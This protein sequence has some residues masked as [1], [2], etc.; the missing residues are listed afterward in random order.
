MAERLALRGIVER[1]VADLAQHAEAAA[2]FRL[3]FANLDKKELQR[4]VELLVKAKK[5]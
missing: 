1:A 3:G 2:H 4:A 5:G